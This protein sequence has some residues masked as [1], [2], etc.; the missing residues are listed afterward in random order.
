MLFCL[1]CRCRLSGKS[2]YDIHVGDYAYPPDVDNLDILRS[3][4]PLPFLVKHLFM[5]DSADS[6]A[7]KLLKVAKRVQEFS[8]IDMIFRRC[9]D[10]LSIEVLPEI[11]LLPSPSLNAFTFGTDEK[12][13]VVFNSIALD[14]LTEE[15]LMAL[16]AHELAHVKSKHMLYHTL[17]EYLAG[18]LS[19]S[20]S[21]LGFSFAS[22]PIKAA[23]LSWQ[24]ESEISAD[25][26]SLLIANNL[27]HVE[28]LMAKLLCYGDPANPRKIPQTNEVGPI[29]SVTEL[30]QNHPLYSRRVML[31]EEYY[32]SKEFEQAR[33]KITLRQQITKALVPRCRLCGAEKR[34]E[35]IFCKA[36]GR[37]NA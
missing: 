33:R 1:R 8:S 37:S 14:V 7:S 23:L 27:C 26:A 28:S 6:L 5:K 13:I 30:F 3:A 10:L 9:A 11:F 32:R 29:E 16:L 17:A 4:G 20:A 31:L 21:V 36:C 15:E 22:L 19:F 25:R 35:E 18:G 2:T 12:P 24:R 34:L